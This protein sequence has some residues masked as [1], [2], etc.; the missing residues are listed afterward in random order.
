M[1]Q[2]IQNL[3]KAFVGESQARNRYTIYAKTAKKE[4]YEQMSEIFMLTADQE[5]EHA[6]WLFRMINDLKKGSDKDSN[7]IKIEASVPTVVGNTSENL[8]AAIS[9][10][11]HEHKSMYPEFSDTA[12]QEGFPEIAARLKSIAK[13]EE[14]HEGRFQRLL[15]ELEAGTVFKK[16]EETTWVCRKCGYS[17][18]GKEAPET[19][20]SCNHPTAYFQSSCEN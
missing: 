19:C 6:K 5:R 7:E 1:N 15:T 14:H 17:H 9:G 11:N 12:E 2:T 20:P 4:G 10:E 18:S 16:D 13:A 8:K 3:A